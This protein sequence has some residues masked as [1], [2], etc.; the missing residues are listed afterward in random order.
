[1]ATYKGIQGYSVQNLSSDPTASGAEGQLWYNS[2][3]GK[4]RIAVTGAG[5]W[6]S[7]GDMNTVR[8]QTAG[9]GT[10]TAALAAGG[11]TP[12]VTR[13]FCETYDGTTWTE[14][15]N[16][17]TARRAAV[18]AGSTGAGMIVA[19]STPS[20]PEITG[21]TE[22]YDG[23]SWSTSPASLTRAGGTIGLAIAGASSTSALVFGGEPDSP[24]YGAYSETWNGTAWT[25]GNNLTT[26]RAHMAGAGIVTAALGSG[27]YLV[28][29]S[30]TA[31]D[32]VE[33]YDGTSWTETSTDLGTARYKL[34]G[35]GTSTAC[36]VYGGNPG[37]LTVTESFNG[38]TWTEVAD[39]GT[40]TA[41]MGNAQAPT[42][43]NASALAIGG[44]AP[45]YSAITQ[46]WDD[47]VYS[48]KTVTVS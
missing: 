33:S 3:T 23:T 28:G 45:S 41:A 5:A 12:G 42:N 14:G 30:P 43:T 29:V 36:I 24:T 7:G 27:G 38:T 37:S 4:F 17:N 32:K 6:A 16:I 25:E 20:P 35:S 22:I 31:T 18:G 48:V 10:P 11:N 19:G 47:P 44:Y 1:M 46:E 13:D 26:G 40:A 8:S 21:T 39:L 2:N 34:G 15:N 9:V